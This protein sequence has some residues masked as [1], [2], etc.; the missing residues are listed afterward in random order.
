M[1]PP[2]EDF[3]VLNSVNIFPHFL[4]TWVSVNYFSRQQVAFRS[5]HGGKLSLL[6]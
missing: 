2:W 1:D 4:E 6:E 5:I 3:P